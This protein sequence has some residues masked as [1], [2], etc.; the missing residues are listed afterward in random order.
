MVHKE[1]VSKAYVTIEKSAQN[2]LLSK[3]HAENRT[4]WQCAVLDDPKVVVS[5]VSPNVT[6]LV[7]TSHSLIDLLVSLF[8]YRKDTQELPSHFHNKCWYPNKGHLDTLL[9]HEN[10]IRFKERKYLKAN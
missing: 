7:H 2:N 6:P 10:V 3:A 4:P 8:L 1:S 9:D 5:R